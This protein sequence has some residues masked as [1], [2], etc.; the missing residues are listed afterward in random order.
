MIIRFKTRDLPKNKITEQ[1][2]VVLSSDFSFILTARIY[3]VTD[4]YCD[5]LTALTTK[6]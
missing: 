3:R 4:S 1:S 2:V 6:I 5:W